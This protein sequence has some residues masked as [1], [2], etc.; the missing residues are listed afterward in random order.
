M[1]VGK[2][3]F[4]TIVKPAVELHVPDTVSVNF[5]LEIGSVSESVTVQDGAPLVNTQDAAVRTV[6]DRKFVEYMPLNGKS[7][8][9]PIPLTPGVAVTSS[10]FQ[11]QGQF[12]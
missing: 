2:D 10:T 1:T 4:K 7:F 8:Q 3:G 12:S 9:S 11:N 5:A 6:V